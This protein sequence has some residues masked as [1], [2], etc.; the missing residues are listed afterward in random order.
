MRIHIGYELTFQ[1]AGPT[2]MILLLYVRPDRTAH[3]ESVET[4][5]TQPFTPVKTYVDSFGNLCG[6]LIAPTGL[7]K[8]SYDNICRDSGKIE[9]TG[10]GALQHDIADLPPDVLRFLIASRY[11]EVDRFGQLA[12][13]LF[14][15]TPPGWARAQAVSDWVHANI[16]FGYEYANATKTAYD[17]LQDRRGVC[18][19]FMHLTVTFLRA[20]GIPARYATGYLG[21]I[22]IPPQPYPMDFSASLEVYLG[23][24]WWTM[25]P[26]HNVPRIGRILMAVGRDAADTALTTSFGNATLTGFKVWTD[27]L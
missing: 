24:R 6:R 1:T 19:D 17:V 13:Q 20:L 2:P 14:G 8:L 10:V 15:N 26:R 27:E 7:F 21:D 3:L 9:E 5:L 12:W 16:Q 25:D 4:L 22:G 23:H 11:C 18:R